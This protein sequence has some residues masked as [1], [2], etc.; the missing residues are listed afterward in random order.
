[1]FLFST[2]QAFELHTPDPLY[3]FRDSGE[4]S[5]MKIEAQIPLSSL[6]LFFIVF[7]LT[8]SFH[9]QSGYFSYSLR[10]HLLQHKRLKVGLIC[11]LQSFLISCL[12][13]C[14]IIVVSI[15]S[16]SRMLSACVA[17]FDLPTLTWICHMQMEVRDQEE[18]DHL[19]GQSVLITVETGY[20]TPRG[21]PL[22]PQTTQ[23]RT[24]PTRSACMCWKVISNISCVVSVLW[25]LQILTLDQLDQ[26]IGRNKNIKHLAGWRQ[27]HWLLLCWRPSWQQT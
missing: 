18:L 12:G 1:M 11:A 19:S 3:T 15:S 6:S 27:N 7:S 4:C 5:E 10:R 26:L 24:L 22:V 9:L 14:I 8:R 16:A 21:A 25:T 23:I 2:C 17:M 20:E 13:F